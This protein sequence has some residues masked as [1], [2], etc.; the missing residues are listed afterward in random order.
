MKH[1][2]RFCIIWKTNIQNKEQVQEKIKTKRTKTKD[3]CL[4]LVGPFSCIKSKMRCWCFSKFQFGQPPLLNGEK[5]ATS[6]Y[7]EMGY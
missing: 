2:K 7:A 5:T 1:V 3:K 4:P 6:T